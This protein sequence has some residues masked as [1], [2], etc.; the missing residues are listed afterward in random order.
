MHESSGLTPSEPWNP[1]ISW[2]PMVTPTRSLEQ[3]IARAVDTSFMREIFQRELPALART[4]IRVVECRAHA[5]KLRG[6]LKT[7]RLRV[8]YRVTVEAAP[9]QRYQRSLL[10]TLPVTGDQFLSPE[11][12]AQCVAALGHPDVTPFERLASF[13]ADLQMGIQFFPVDL[14]LS[15]LIALT[16][17]AAGPLLAPYIREARE[18]A[19][20]DADRGAVV[21]YKPGSRC[22]V[23]FD[24]RLSGAGLDP[25]RRT[26]YG[27]LF[28]DDRGEATYREMRAL[29]EVSPRWRRLRMPEPLGY[30]PGHRLLLMA[31]APGGGELDA[32]IGCL[33]QDLPLPAGVDAER[34]DCCMAVVAEALVELHRSGVQPSHERTFRSEL[35]HRRKDFRLIRDHHPELAPILTALFEALEAGAPREEPL[36]PCH[37]GFRHNQFMADDHCLTVVDWDG[38]VRGHPALDAASFICSLGYSAIVEPSAARE[39]E[40][41]AQVFRG[42]FLARE[43]ELRPRHLALYEALALADMALRMLRLLEPDH[44]DLGHVRRLLAGASARAA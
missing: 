40:R 42:E 44:A 22:V 2:N 18:G 6:A 31:E 41:L 37:G 5:V 38:V 20:I 13:I 8:V 25:C 10:G 15:R 29:W 43:P 30:D 19:T 27:K 24:V 11:L 17:S 14:D 12:L 16:A 36:V 33:E 9:G 28:A 32:W 7:G 21:H 34:L 23:K 1:G 26:I 3:L 35:A 4:P 39:L